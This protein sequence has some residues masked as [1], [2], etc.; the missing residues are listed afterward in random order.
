M[1]R[2]LFSGLLTLAIILSLFSGLGVTASAASE[3]SAS[4]DLIELVKSFE[5][6]SANAYWDVKQW[7]IGYGTVSTKG[8][9]ISREDAQ[10]A[11]EVEIAKIDT[12]L[13]S[14]TAKNNL[15]LTQSQH[16]ALVSLS[17]NCGTAWM[18]SNGRL[19]SAVVNGK[20]GND[21]LFAIS[22]WANIDS[23]PNTGLLRRRLC[24]ANLY[25]NGVYSKTVPTGF[26]YVIFDPKGGIPGHSSEDKMQG[27]NSGSAVSIMVENPTKTGAA[28]GGWF[29]S[30]TGGDAITQLGAHTAGKRLYA[31]WGT[32]V[33]VT[34]EYANIRNGAGVAYTQVGTAH[35]GDTLVILE[36][37]TVDSSLWGRCAQGWLA[38]ENTDYTG[39]SSGSGTEEVIATGKVKCTTS[40]NIRSGAGTGYSIAGKAT[41]GTAVKIY[42]Q[43]TVGSE[44]WA[45]VDGGWIRMDYIVLDS[46]SSSGSGSWETGGSTTTGKTG[47]VTG[48]AVRIRAAAG[49]GGAVVGS[50]NKGDKVTILEQTTV[51]G[52]SWGRIEKG[53]ICMN[54]VKLDEDSGNNSG[55][56]DSE[57][58]EKGTVN[59]NSLNVRSGAG[60]SFERV[61]TLSKGAEVTV[62]EKKTVGSVQWGRIGTNRWICLS[63]V[64]FSGS[65][66]NSGSNSGSNSD[67]TGNQTGTVTANALNVRS[68]AGT[69]FSKVGTLSKGDKVTVYE[70]K[71]VGS[72]K[73]GR[74]GTN[75]WVC[76][77][78][79]QK[80]EGSSSSE[81]V[82]ATGTVTATGG[83]NVRSGAGTN[84]SRVAT[85]A[86]GTK[87]S[88]YE[89][90]TVGGTKWGRTDKG[91]VCMTYVSLGNGSGSGL[92]I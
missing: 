77:T 76:L 61:G 13:N 75:R 51:D 57:T 64:S 67:S 14:F 3:L 5:G 86:S 17:F 68:A 70:T 42:E 44:K 27:Y 20:T 11:L 12:E 84:Y 74:I 29:T 34:G 78:Y 60:T 50:A 15:T 58:G 81:T 9:T 33:S 79:V 19:R 18:K 28:F 31:Q 71:T 87:I 92:W 22:L 41:N 89:E 56:S 53:W 90:K 39:E 7:S 2:K 8:A 46:S 55:S 16:D 82:V 88:I 65:G 48:T 62:L 35:K 73:W 47:V 49:I 66:N 43:K 37:T 63:Y 21:F 83:L 85:I 23:V 80:G 69:N 40:V 1:K 24:E 72:V 25:L 38:L 6:F 26:T 52:V 10:A 4:E 30:A 32:K 91:W 36:T 54:Y 45:R 59:A